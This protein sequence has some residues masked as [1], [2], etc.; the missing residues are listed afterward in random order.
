MKQPRPSE[1]QP[2]RQRRRAD[3]LALQDLVARHRMI[4]DLGRIITSEINLDQL[5]DLI[6]KQITGLMQCETGSVFLYD[7]PTD[8]LWSMVSCDLQ[9]NHIRISSR[10]GIAGWVFAHRTP[11]IINQP[12]QDP[13]FFSGVDRQT[14]FRT[15]NLLCIPL[16]NR[17]KACTGTLQVLNKKAG[18]FTGRDQEV[19][20]SASHYVTIAL[21]NATL[22][23]D[24]KALDR[25][26]QKTIHHL[27]HELKTPLAVLRGSFELIRKRLAP[28]A[29]AAVE[30]SLQRGVRSLDRLTELQQKIDDILTYMKTAGE[31]TAPRWYELLKAFVEEIEAAHPDAAWLDH[32]KGCINA[33]VCRQPCKEWLDVGRVLA[34]VCESVRAVLDA[35]DLCLMQQF[36]S[37]ARVCTDR[38]VL[39]KVCCGLLKNA[40]ENTPDEGCIE[41][42]VQNNCDA[43]SIEFC[44]HGIGIAPAH[45]KM[46]FSGFFPTQATEAYASKSPYLFNAGGAGVDLL[47]IKTFADQLGFKVDF[48]S[49]RCPGLE[50]ADGACPGKIS[51]CSVIAQRSE[52]LDHGG[53]TFRVSFAAAAG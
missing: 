27:S 32:L 14:G 22:Y 12:Y 44:D 39:E 1:A 53:S 47:R 30:K 11:Q 36:D 33:A 29:L 40:I 31:V 49:R 23:E 34:D 25:V 37:G 19:L 46:I 45:Q 24:L 17:N 18:P 28:E 42:R 43:V 38:S 4:G 21:E 10:C 51:A 50:R 35:R 2:R 15:R 9:Q 3:D 6:V 5:F 8:E 16:I 13:R 41:I 48:E 52:C 7:A 20:L 26:K